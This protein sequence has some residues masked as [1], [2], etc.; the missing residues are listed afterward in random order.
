MWIS[1]STFTIVLTVCAV[2]AALAILLGRSD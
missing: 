2:A 1:A